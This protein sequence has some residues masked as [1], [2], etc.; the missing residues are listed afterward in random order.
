MQIITITQARQTTT[1]HT[2]KTPSSSETDQIDVDTQVVFSTISTIQTAK[3]SLINTNT[4]ASDPILPNLSLE[5][6]LIQSATEL[7]VLDASNTVSVSV[8]TFGS[9]ETV[10]VLATDIEAVFTQ[11]SASPSGEPLSELSNFLLLNNGWAYTALNHSPLDLPVQPPEQLTEQQADNNWAPWRL[12]ESNR[13]EIQDLASGAWFVLTGIKVDTSTKTPAEISGVFQNASVDSQILSTTTSWHTLELSADGLFTSKRTVLSNSGLLSSDVSFALHT[14]TSANGRS[15]T[16]SG[17]TQNNDG[18]TTAALSNTSAELSEIAAD[19]FGAF[20]LLEDGITLEMTFADGT[21]ER[22]LF[23][24]TKDSDVYID[25][26]AYLRTGNAS[27][28]LLADMLQLLSAGDESDKRTE[29][30]NALIKAERTSNKD[31]QL[32]QGN[33]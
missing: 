26:K 31:K 6:V 24:K 1:A 19:M 17:T 25:G 30:L 2:K 3:D 27:A 9:V 21:V 20:R 23:L 8:E 15:S 14:V 33:S 28:T 18:L 5:D 29:W 22:Q 7:T 11:A 16:F 32:R 4:G 12:V 10:K 13:Y